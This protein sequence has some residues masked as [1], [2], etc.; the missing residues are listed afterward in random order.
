MQ[1]RKQYHKR[2]VFIKSY[3]ACDQVKGKL[4]VDL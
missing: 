2:E 1:V 4:V 3:M